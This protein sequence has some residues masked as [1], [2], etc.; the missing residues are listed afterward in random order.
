MNEEILAVVKIEPDRM[1]L[2]EEWTR[3]LGG[4]FHVIADPFE[5]A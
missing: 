2:V 4:E 3:L 1:P 5:Y